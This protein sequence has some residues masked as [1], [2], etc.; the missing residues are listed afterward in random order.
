MAFVRAS[1]I[2][3]VGCLRP[4]QRARAQR[5]RSPPSAHRLSRL[6]AQKRMRRPPSQGRRAFSVVSGERASGREELPLKTVEPVHAALPLRG[7][8]PEL[9]PQLAAVQLRPEVADGL[10]ADV[11]HAVA[12][13]LHQVGHVLVHRAL[14]LHGPC[15]AL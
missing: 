5:E 8:A 6:G 13:A 2:I 3:A 9:E 12:E 11:L 7:G 15:D 1:D 14:V 4:A 10:A